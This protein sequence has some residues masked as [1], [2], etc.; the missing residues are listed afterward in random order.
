MPVPTLME[1]A[2]CRPSFAAVNGVL[3]SLVLSSWAKMPR[4]NVP[5]KPV[6]VMKLNSLP[7]I[8]AF[9]VNVPAVPLPSVIF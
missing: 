5:S 8:P 3:S 6:A 2:A 4:F 1:K 9:A 7:A